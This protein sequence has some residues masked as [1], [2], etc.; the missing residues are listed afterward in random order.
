MI[1]L[2]LRTLLAYL[3]DTLPPD[4]ARELGEKLAVSPQAQELAERLKKVMRKRSVSTPPSGPEGSASDANIVAAYLSDSLPPEIVAEFEKAA[5]ESDAHLAELAACH[6][7]LTLVL[8]QQVKVPPTA[9]RRMYGLVKGPES[10]PTRKPN[11]ALPVGGLPG[12]PSTDADDADA[13]YLL[14]LPAYERSKPGAARLLPLA[15]AAL[16][17]LG[18][19]VAAYMLWPTDA[20]STENIAATPSTPAPTSALPPIKPEP[21]PAT[22][23]SEPEK[24]APVEPVKPMPMPEPVKP[25]PEPMPMPI[26]KPPAPAPAEEPAINVTQPPKSSGDTVAKC[27]TPDNRV[28]VLRPAGTEDMVRFMKGSELRSGDKLICLPG[29]TGTLKFYSGVVVDLFANVTP[30]LQ[31]FPFQET[32]LTAHDPYPGTGT[33]LTLHTGRLYLSSAKAEGDV[34]RVRFRDEVWDVAIPDAKAEVMVEI[35][36]QLGRGAKPD[37]RTTKAIFAVVKGNAKLTTTS[38]EI[39][40]VPQGQLVQYE[41]KTG[42]TTGPKKPD[43][44]FGR[45]FEYISR[46]LP[47]PDAK[48]GALCLDVLEKFATRTKGNTTIKGALV[49][50]RSEVKEPTPAYLTGARWS[51]LCAGALGEIAELADCLNDG[52]RGDLNA[53]AVFTVRNLLAS[54]P[55]LEEPFLK[56]AESKLRL[57]KKQAQEGFLHSIHGMT[58]AELDDPVA[59]D[60]MIEQ[61]EATEVAQRGAAMYVLLSEIDPKAVGKPGLMLPLNESAEARTAAVKAWKKHVMDLKKGK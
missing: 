44:S 8:S 51:V 49:E 2:T 52:Q 9:Y 38:R 33:D 29:Y 31:L 20:K 24:P 35:Q 6:Q 3:D 17:A 14:G 46:T 43:E 30:D 48:A 45:N 15:V 42:K 23:V 5:T 10:I 28:L 4:E 41:S 22:K 57:G 55:E 40:A 18:F 13:P 36:H 16:C 54:S 21:T 47:A 32:A 1:R 61:L 58:Q 27:D 34:V 59:V 7:I 11:L 60:A 26:P 50:L 53:A 12:D 25:M 39:L 56:L 37:P 19:G